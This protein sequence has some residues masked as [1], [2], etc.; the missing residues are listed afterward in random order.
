LRVKD[1]KIKRL[2]DYKI[3]YPEDY[4]P[5]VRQIL[6]EIDSGSKRGKPEV[7]WWLKRW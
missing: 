5:F 1:K 6:F 2:N 7:I 3:A 4:A